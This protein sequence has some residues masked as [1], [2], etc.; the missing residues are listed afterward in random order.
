M[1]KNKYWEFK[2]IANNEAELY[3]YGEIASWGE[4]YEAHSVKSFK[5]ELDELGDVDVLNIYQNSPG[6][7]V[8]EG[9]TI[10]NMLKRH[11]AKKIIHI[12]GL[13]ASISSVISTVG[14]TVIMPK[15][16]MMMVH[17]AWTYTAGNSNDLRKLADDLDKIN[18]SIRQAYLDKAGDK[19][20]EATITE[21]M[22][23]ESWLTAEDCYRYGL[24]DVVGDEKN[25]VAKYDLNALNKYKNVPI[26]Y[27]IT[28]A[29]SMYENKELK[30]TIDE[31]I[32]EVN[33]K[34]I[35]ED[36]NDKLEEEKRMILE[37]LDLI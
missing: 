7:D 13:S 29:K 15:N 5:R 1:S 8:Y 20:D 11:K 21:L 31:P 37:D 23:K 17:N 4:G 25:M 16:S 22:D 12:D 9:I 32:I 19:L 27:V 2:N 28:Q 24:C 14:D 30:E 36:I 18:S 26:D 33:D 35:V 10:A 34:V 3:L 6:G